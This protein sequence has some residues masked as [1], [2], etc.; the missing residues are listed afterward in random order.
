MNLD[1]LD[2]E[3]EGWIWL[4]WEEIERLQAERNRM[5]NALLDNA[6]SAV[7]RRTSRPRLPA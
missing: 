3:D 1:D 7:T 6:T 4:Q 5:M 2:H